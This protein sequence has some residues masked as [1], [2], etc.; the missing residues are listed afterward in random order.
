MGTTNNLGDTPVVDASYEPSRCGCAQAAVQ[1]ESENIRAETTT[2][3]SSLLD[4]KQCTI[5]CFVNKHPVS[6]SLFAFAAAL[7]LLLLA[8]KTA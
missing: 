1:R 7:I 6:A 3:T 8:N 5:K 4:D 2:T